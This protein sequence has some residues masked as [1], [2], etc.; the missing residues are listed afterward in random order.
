M[1]ENF[2]G[3]SSRMGLY[4]KMTGVFENN[5]PVY[6]NSDNSNYLWMIGTNWVVGSDYTVN[7]VGIRNEVSVELSYFALIILYNQSMETSVQK[8]RLVGCIMMVI[9][10][11]T[12]KEMSDVLIVTSTLL[13]LNAVSLTILYLIFMCNF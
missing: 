3:Q 9:G 10:E 6:S 12:V 2:S 7:S 13:L 5:L 11:M 8:M 1:I 4:T